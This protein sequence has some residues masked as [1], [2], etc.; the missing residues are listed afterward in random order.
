[1]TEETRPMEDEATPPEPGAAG[2]DPT[3]EPAGGPVPDPEAPAPT[4]GAGDVRT[5]WILAAVT[6]GLLAVVGLWWTVNRGGD[7][8]PPAGQPTEDVPA[9][10]PN[11][12]LIGPVWRLLEIAEPGGQ[13]LEVSN[14][15]LYTLELLFD[16]TAVALADC[17]AGKGSFTA[18][19]TAISLEIAFT[20]AACGPES[21]FDA[22]AQGLA[23][24]TTYVV[25]GD[26]LTL[27][28]GG[29]GQL[30]YTRGEVAAPATEAPAAGPMPV[31]VITGPSQA[32]VGEVLTFDGSGSTPI[33]E[34]R[35]HAWDFGN[36]TR[37]NGPTV[38][39]AYPLPGRYLVRLTVLDERMRQATATTIVTVEAADQ[40][41]PTAI[42]TGPSEGRVGEDLSFEGGGS[43]AGG[44]PIATYAWTAG[45]AESTGPVSQESLRVTY[46]RPGT[47]QVLLLVTDESGLSDATSHQVVIEDAA[48]PTPA[49]P[50]AVI[51]APDRVTVGE[52]ATFD[53]SGSTASDPIVS[54]LWDFGDGTRANA[55]RIEH[56]YDRAGTF[57][58]TLEVVDEQGRS[59]V[60]NKT[61]TVDRAATEPPEAVIRGPEEA[62]VGEEVTFDASASSGGDSPIDRYVWH[63]DS[64][65]GPG[66]DV[67]PT[68]TGAF[69]R[70]GRR[71]VFLTVTNAAGMS[72]SASLEVT[73][74]AGLEDTTW[75]FL[76]GVPGSEISAVFGEGQITGFAG[77][78]SYTSSYDVRD[79]MLSVG[80]ITTTGRV[81]TGPVADQEAAFLEALAAAQS[82]AIEGA[83]LTITSATGVPLEFSA[84]TPTAR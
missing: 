55:V 40:S 31:A 73:V 77:C 48:R 24:A 41:P 42:I 53:A 54:Y 74:A 43:Q 62:I 27:G 56:A 32:R 45:G 80:E 47:Y 19:A 78:N 7:A 4:G 9:G 38:Q 37:A 15:D 44:A 46:D 69:D 70:P 58:V 66:A 14:P 51:A 33:G 52:A 57:V 6:I 68:V 3:G 65:A 2:G 18:D 67:G 12:E 49:P 81:C 64:P 63:L 21:L 72:D 8:A 36:G 22:Y 28:Y 50:V 75:I 17:N 79:E 34:I 61:V 29:G 83:T 76:G 13:R 59:G 10:V 35:V 84:R 30:V 5:T 60:A 39:Q 1:M 16:G 26:G 11:P 20:R 25:Q 71:H 23:S 82:Y